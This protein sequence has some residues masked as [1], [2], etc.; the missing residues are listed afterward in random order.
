MAK[1]LKQKIY[2]NQV[3]RFIFSAGSGALVD[4]LVF[5]VMHFYVLTSRSYRIFSFP[6]SNYTLS[7]T[8]SFFCGVVVNF[9]ITRYLVFSESKSK[10]SK[11]FFRFMLVP[12]VGYFTSLI[13]I[14]IFIQNVGMAPDIARISTLGS[15]FFASFFVH[16]FFSFSLSLKHRRAT[17]ADHK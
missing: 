17:T 15:L 13:L 3:A 16:K 10:S 1:S 8:I 12:I 14:E 2:K 5:R 6:L 7:L 4:V 9:L 11:Q